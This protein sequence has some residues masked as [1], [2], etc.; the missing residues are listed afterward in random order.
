MLVAKTDG[1]EKRSASAATPTPTLSSSL[2]RR[3]SDSSGGA[4]SRVKGVLSAVHPWGRAAATAGRRHRRA[5]VGRTPEGI[6]A[7]PGLLPGSGGPGW[8]LGGRVPE[9][10]V[11]PSAGAKGVVKAR[12]VGLE[13]GTGTR[14]G[15]TAVQTTGTRSSITV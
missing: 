10:V 6:S 7:A 8:F 2:A 9:G 12:L 1:Y 5:R 14:P 15:I 4:G 11:S 13:G 3:P